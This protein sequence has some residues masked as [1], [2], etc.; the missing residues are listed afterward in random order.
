M[1]G[2]VYVN[3]ICK[4]RTQIQNTNQSPA[5]CIWYVDRSLLLCKNIREFLCYDCN[6]LINMGGKESTLMAQEINPG[7]MEA[8]SIKNHG[9]HQH[10]V[11]RSHTIGNVH[12]GSSSYGV[13]KQLQTARSAAGTRISREQCKQ[14]ALS[15]R[16]ESTLSSVPLALFQ[17]GNNAIGT[18]PR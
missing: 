9:Y 4:K 13:E 12:M 7:S 15:I 17:T 5:P 8:Y 18:I 11:T 1:Y 6:S 14:S 10:G 3:H 2:G 16:K